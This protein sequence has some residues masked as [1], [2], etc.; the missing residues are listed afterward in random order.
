MKKII[1]IGILAVFLAA[2][3]SEKYNEFAQ[4]LTDKDVKFYGAFWCPH[5]AR[6]KELF[7][8][9]FDKVNYIECSLP[10]KSGQTEVCSSANITNYPTWDFGDERKQ[11]LL[12]LQQ[13]SQKTGCQLPQV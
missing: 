1:L 6:Q 11:G 7:G 10:D 3:A 13:L 2:C 4:C 9:S 5:C 8:S 12:T